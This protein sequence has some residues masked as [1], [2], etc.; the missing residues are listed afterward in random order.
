MKR[1]HYFGDYKITAALAPFPNFHYSLWFT[2]TKDEN[3]NKN[4][5]IWILQDWSNFNIF[6]QVS[7]LLNVLD[8]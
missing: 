5:E 1:I 3:L 4:A 6:S 2:E 7:F 8:I